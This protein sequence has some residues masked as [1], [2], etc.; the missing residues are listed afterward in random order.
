MSASEPASAGITTTIDDGV[1]TIVLDRPEA[2]NSLTAGMLDALA[3]TLDDVA[4]DSAVEVIVLTGTGRAF[5]AG[6]DLKAL[7]QRR[8]DGGK[9]GD[10]L[11]LPA[12]AVTERLTTIPKVVI[13]R[14][15]GFCFT[16]ALE[17]VLA[18][19]MAIATD[20]ARFGDTHAKFGLRPTWGMSQR[21]V[22]TVGITRARELSYT[23]RT[24]TG[25][26]AAAWGVV[27]RA[28][29]AAELD[30]AV[31]ALVAEVRANSMGS[32]AAYKDLYRVALDGGVG[33]GLRYEAATDY[34]ID[35]TEPR[36]AGF[37]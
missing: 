20:E 27:T 12:R 8:L 7:G 14:V 29:P 5:S 18:C 25:A 3:A 17:L 33:D 23:A 9:V 21:L 34:P 26:Q 10:I 35:D 16:G 22:A 6:V 32:L 37:R 30:A 2:L 31:A 28:V 36:V 4:A 24:F 1:A 11:D 19:D 15:N 13:A